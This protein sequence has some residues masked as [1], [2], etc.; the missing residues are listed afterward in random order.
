MPA[1]PAAAPAEIR[2]PCLAIVALLF[3]YKVSLLSPVDP[4]ISSAASVFLAHSLPR[5]QFQRM[6]STKTRVCTLTSPDAT[7]L[8]EGDV[9]PL[10]GSASERI[11]T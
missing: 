7:P 9:T 1:L 11:W 8:L 2:D 4:D 5:D 3:S 10:Y 6:C